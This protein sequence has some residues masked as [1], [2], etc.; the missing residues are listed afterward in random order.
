MR[1]TPNIEKIAK[2]KVV[3]VG[4]GGGNTVNTM[5]ASGQ[6]VGVDFMAINTDR[7]ALNAVN[8]DEVL[9]IGS[10]LTDGLGS[11]SDPE[12]GKK[13]AEESKEEI[14]KHLEGYHMIF[15]T[16]GMGGGTGTGASPI[17]A[18]IAKEVVN[19][20]TVAVVTT[21]FDFEGVKRAENAKEGVMQLKDVVDALIVI[22]NQKLLDLEEKNLQFEK[23]FAL[24]DSVLTQGVKGISDI[25]V[26]PGYV[27]VD[28]EDVRTIM[29]NAGTALMGVG[30]ATG[31]DRAQI[32]VEKALKNPLMGVDIQGAT[33]ILYNITGEDV[34]MTEIQI[35]AD[36][37]YQS[38]GER[39]NIIFGAGNYGKNKGALCV[40]IIA[41]GFDSPYTNRSYPTSF[42]SGKFVKNEVFK[43]DND[44]I[45][46]EEDLKTDENKNLETVDDTDDNS[47]PFKIPPFLR[48]GF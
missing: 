46:K 48:R 39:A 44:K 32:A 34:T 43:V 26:Q 10:K 8:A 17:V 22:P 1:V 6:I 4:G 27:N 47:D 9:Q 28:I 38:A 35:I 37:I 15:I 23:A 19:A 41:T 18:S 7:Q 45:V 12:V 24:V 36:K 3:G 14:K 20:L 30:E 29:K 11:G 40:T 33:G 31:E 42:T 16:A 21:P 5:I 2:I 13:A 25:I